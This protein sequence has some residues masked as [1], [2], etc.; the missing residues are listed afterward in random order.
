MSQ[1]IIL[2]VVLLR[3]LQLIDLAGEFLIQLGDIV[4]RTLVVLLDSFVDSIKVSLLIINFWSNFNIKG[5]LMRLD[6]SCLCSQFLEE[7]RVDSLVRLD[8]LIELF[9]EDIM[10]SV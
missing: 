6:I 1:I 5:L 9:E 3:L 4:L 8:C 10:L 7:G 2:L